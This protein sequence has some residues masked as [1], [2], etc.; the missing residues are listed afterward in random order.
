MEQEIQEEMQE[1]FEHA[2]ASADPTEAD[3]YRH[4]YAVG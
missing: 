2:L 1:A 4:V 3:L